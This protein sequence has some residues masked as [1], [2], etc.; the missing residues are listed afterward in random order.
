MTVDYQLVKEKKETYEEETRGYITECMQQLS[1]KYR[2]ILHL[3]YYEEYS[4]REI[5]ELLHIKENTVDSRL[6]RGREKLKQIFEKG[7]KE[8]EF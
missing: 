7:E 8:Y 5:A 4:I 3:Y 2:M 1:G 6:S